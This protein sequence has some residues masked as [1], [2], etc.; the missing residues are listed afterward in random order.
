MALMNLPERRVLTSIGV[1]M[2]LS[3]ALSIPAAATQ[4]QQSAMLGAS[5]CSGVPS[6]WVVL[7]GN[8]PPIM[9]IAH[10]LRA[11]DQTQQMILSINFQL[12][13]QAELDELLREQQDPNSPNYLKPITAQEF[14]ARFG[15]T[16]EMIAQVSEFLTLHHLHIIKT[17]GQQM[18]FS[19]S[20]R[21]VE[22]AFAIQINDYQIEGQTG[23][24][25]ANDPAVPSSIAPYIAA[26]IGLNNFS[27][28]S[29]PGLP[30]P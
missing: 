26:V 21:Q 22:C 16:T 19:G 4:I 15:P 1:L 7:P 2:V 11:T 5:A 27:R 9:Q 20:V 13:N 14:Q 17:Q 6:G 25:P 30:T 8:R 18:Q 28:P 24:G 10:L 3:L 29:P 23:F 12:R